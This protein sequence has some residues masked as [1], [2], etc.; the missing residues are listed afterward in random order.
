[1]SGNTIA[2]FLLVSAAQVLMSK[3]DREA[4]PATTAAVI[5]KSLAGGIA[6]I[7]M[8]GYLAGLPSAYGWD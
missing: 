3:P 1:M 5:L 4:G 2:C 7:A 8:L 6:F